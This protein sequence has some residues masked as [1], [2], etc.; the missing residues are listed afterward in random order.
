MSAAFRILIVVAILCTGWL[1]RPG[2]QVD[3]SP[4]ALAVAEEFGATRVSYESG[5]GA[6]RLDL[7]L[8]D[9]RWHEQ[10]GVEQRETARDVAR[11]A[12][13]VSRAE[14]FGLPDTIWVHFEK[15][16]ILGTG[17]SGFRFGAGEL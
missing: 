1:L 12:L 9:R 2:R 15:R 13:E 14:G 4:L 8:S 7:V 3:R 17:R 16:G 11:H 10:S 5:V 6:L